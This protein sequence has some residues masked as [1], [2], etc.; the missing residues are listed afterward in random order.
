VS[1]LKEVVAGEFQY[2]VRELLA[3][4]KSI[5][6]LITKFQDANARVNRSIIKAVTQC[7]CIKINAEKQIVPEDSDFDELKEAMKTHLEGSLCDSCRDII[8][9]EIGRN[10]FYLVSICDTLDLDF[11]DA[12]IKENE[13]VKL[14]G[15][16]NLR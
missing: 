1:H 16:Y 14:L 8:E 11:Y 4:N 13:R 3:R 10:L 12:I 5:L 15:N 6:D 9:R 7:G 2:T